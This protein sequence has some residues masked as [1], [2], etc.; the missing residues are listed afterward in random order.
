MNPCLGE[1]RGDTVSVTGT[2]RT[3]GLQWCHNVGRLFLGNRRRRI[4]GDEV[5]AL[6]APLGNEKNLYPRVHSIFH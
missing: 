1:F 5:N 2:A 3:A 4:A 6:S